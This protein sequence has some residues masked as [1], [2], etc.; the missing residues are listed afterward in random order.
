MQSK[1][2]KSPAIKEDTRQ[3]LEEKPYHLSTPKGKKITIGEEREFRSLE[4]VARV[5]RKRE[6]KKTN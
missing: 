3:H 6:K 5:P 1:K 2:L 4:I